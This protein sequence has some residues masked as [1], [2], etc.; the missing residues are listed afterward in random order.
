[1]EN[2]NSNL[3]ILGAFIL[4]AAVGATLGILFAP[5]KGS[6][7]RRKILNDAKL[8]T[9]GL[10]HELIEKANSL[11]EKAED[12]EEMAEEKINDLSKSVKSKLDGLVNN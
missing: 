7:T 2:S 9:E 1:M 4:G 10:K 8:L 12:L 6:R 3:K 11:L 5:N